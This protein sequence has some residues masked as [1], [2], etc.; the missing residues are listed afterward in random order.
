MSGRRVVLAD[1]QEDTKLLRLHHPT[2]FA[3]THQVISTR[4]C[5]EG[6]HGQV[7]KEP[8]TEKLYTQYLQ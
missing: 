4:L 3:S 2:W 8:R 7:R 1:H 5:R 6:I